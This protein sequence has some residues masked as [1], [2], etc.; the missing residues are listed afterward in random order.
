MSIHVYWPC[1][2]WSRLT[3]WMG[4]LEHI[5]VPVNVNPQGIPH[6]QL[7]GFWQL[8]SIL[9]RRLWQWCS[10]PRAVQTYTIKRFPPPW[11]ENRWNPDTNVQARVGTLK[12]EIIFECLPVGGGGRAWGFTLT[13]AYLFTCIWVYWPREWLSILTMWMIVWVY[14]PCEW[15]YFF[16]NCEWDC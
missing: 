10:D 16:I 11:V 1:D 2:F 12:K 3:M 6:R 15:D 7:R 13:G 4:L 14:W 5:N 9:P 8:S